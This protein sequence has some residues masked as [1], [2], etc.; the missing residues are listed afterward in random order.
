[1]SFQ[2]STRI[3]EILSQA[4][5]VQRKRGFARRMDTLSAELFAFAADKYP[6]ETYA[7]LAILK[8]TNLLL[9]Y[10][11]TY[12]GHVSVLARPFQVMLDPANTCQLQCPGCVHSSS[13]QK[14][15]AIFDWPDGIMTNN[16][17]D[18]I[19]TQFAPYALAS[20]FFDYDKSPISRDGPPG[21]G[22]LSPHLGIL[23]P[24]A[25]F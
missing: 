13:E 25:A 11:A 17:F 9:G 24:V 20:L 12:H 4:P 3:V 2:P 14:I 7:K 18:K 8:L 21:K 23:K 19:M 10:H 15:G 16:C 22:F 6:S 1:M 5:A